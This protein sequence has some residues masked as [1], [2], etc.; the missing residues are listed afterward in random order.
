MKCRSEFVSNSGSSSYVYV[1]L[2][3]NKRDVFIDNEFECDPGWW[4]IQ[5]LGGC[6]DFS[7]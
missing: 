2:K 3:T 6:S 4:F 5:P 1:Y 7:T